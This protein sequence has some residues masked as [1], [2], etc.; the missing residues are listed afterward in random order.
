MYTS[1]IRITNLFYFLTL[2]SSS[3]STSLIVTSQS[4]TTPFYTMPSPNSNVKSKASPNWLSTT[5]DFEYD[6]DAAFLASLPNGCYR[7]ASVTSQWTNLSSPE[8]L[9]NT[10]YAW[11]PGGTSEVKV[12]R[13]TDIDLYMLLRLFR[14]LEHEAE[15]DGQARRS[16]REIAVAINSK[17]PAA[18]DEFMASIPLPAHFEDSVTIGPRSSLFSQYGSVQH[19]ISSHEVENHTFDSDHTEAGI[20]PFQSLDQQLA[21]S[22]RR[23]Q[24]AD[25]RAIHASNSP[26][27]QA[28]D[29][30]T[31]KPKVDLFD[32]SS[33]I[34]SISQSKRMAIFE[35][36]KVLHSKVKSKE[37]EEMVVKQMT[38][39]LKPGVLPAKS[40]REYSRRYLNHVVRKQ[41]SSPEK[42]HDAPSSNFIEPRITFDLP[43]RPSPT[44]QQPQTAPMGPNEE[45]D[46]VE[47][48]ATPSK[49][50]R[51]IS[52]SSRPLLNPATATN[53]VAKRRTR[54]LSMAERSARHRRLRDEMAARSVQRRSSHLQEPTLP[55]LNA[56]APMQPAQGRAQGG[57]IPQ[58]DEDSEEDLDF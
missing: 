40:T 5:R 27:V 50:Q 8:A 21:D 26:Y 1:H 22:S 33:T 47:G 35:E 58:E 25:R 12:S 15:H 44:S 14:A 36:L 16:V 54:E 52:S 57:D 9:F 49:M 18:V 13:R 24:A 2:L 11:Y 48:I 41:S 20:Y 31:R 23:N 19:R 43:L 56:S 7:G 28:T 10:F 38:P 30:G 53:I 45:V 32:P 34:E 46:Q 6:K 29:V 55:S 51:K 4:S 42:H 39:F 37:A 17:S 3:S